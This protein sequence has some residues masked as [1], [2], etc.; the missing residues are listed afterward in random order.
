MATGVILKPSKLALHATIQRIAKPP[1]WKR[2]SPSGKHI[3]SG[4]HKKGHM[5]A[6]IG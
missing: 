3:C 1:K 2:G 5:E 6:E 4:G